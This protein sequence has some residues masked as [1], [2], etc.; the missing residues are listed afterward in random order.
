MKMKEQGKYKY[1]DSNNRHAYLN[2]KLMTAYIAMSLLTALPAV[3]DV[4]KLK[5]AAIIRIVMIIG[6]IIYCCITYKKDKSSPNIRKS[7]IATYGIIW[8]YSVLTAPS[9]ATLIAIYPIFYL[10]TLYSDKRMMNGV[11]AIT[12]ITIAISIGLSIFGIGKG[13][14]TTDLLSLVLIIMS[15]QGPVIT[16]TLKLFNEDSFGALEEEKNA[17]GNMV[18]D[19]LEIAET[20]NSDSKAIDK[21]M[22]SL[23]KTNEVVTHSV[24]DVSTAIVSVT[25]NINE[26]TKMTG[27]IQDNIQVTKERTENIENI[28]HISQ[29]T[30]QE[31]LQHVNELKG[32]SAKISEVSNTVADNME[33]LREKAEEVQNITGMISGVAEQTNLLALNASIEA[34]RAGDAGKGFA[35]VA[36]EIRKLSEQT[37]QASDNI[38][39]ILNELSDYA[40][41]ASDSVQESLFAT[42][43][44]AEYI[45]SVFKGFQNISNHMTTMDNE[46]TKMGQEMKELSTANNEIVDNISQISAASE[47]ITASLEGTAEDV[48]VNEASF[49]DLRSN[50]KN[51]L[52]E[53]EKSKKYQ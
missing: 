28:A 46:I 34:A 37:K 16:N 3:S 30:I 32:H 20:V 17:Q 43:K 44:Q 26:Q 33:Q 29:A 41:E 4:L 10:L 8:S 21:I 22:D 35:V 45:D 14:L 24:K 48:V 51:V 27:A 18:K 49:V 12:I 2:K 31:N 6:S 53:I 13:G 36:S 5:A 9:A 50:F 39:K 25:D 7:V 38:T 23:V 40:L 15:L 1:K 42:N 47:E 11:S 19:L 52:A